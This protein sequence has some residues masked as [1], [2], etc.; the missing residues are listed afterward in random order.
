MSLARSL[1]ALLPAG[2]WFGLLTG[3]GE[4]AV[5]FARSEFAGHF[6]NVGR[7]SIWAAPLLDAIIFGVIG[8]VLVAVARRKR[9]D[10]LQVSVTVYAFLGALTLLLMYYPLHP[11]ARL[12]LAAG[13][14]VQC[15][16]SAAG[17]RTRFVTIVHATLAWPTQLWRA[18]LNLVRP[19]IVSSPG[20]ASIT[21]TRRA[22][23]IGTGATIGALAMGVHV[24]P[25]VREWSGLRQLPPPPRDA[26]NVLLV[27]L[28]TVR[29]ANLSV[30]GYHRDTTPNL[31]R[32]AAK[33]ALFRR[34][35]SHTSWT[36]PS[37][38]SLFTGRYP[39]EL[40][41]TWQTPLDAAQPTI[42][43]ILTRARYATAGFVAN[44]AY[45]S[46]RRSRPG[47]ATGAADY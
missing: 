38:G 12:A 45:C 24:P 11:W 14:G 2:L 16:R 15:G 13:I 39:H 44:T 4:S 27:V 41:G 31:A 40:S 22:F 18:I 43:E 25:R 37:H 47:F 29:A 46:E 10:L 28:D 9:L 8:A 6:N 34:A 32:L 20:A 33:G 1:A 5:R 3:F 35:Y 23:L 42:A 26:P 7:L 30:Y 36:L 19:P 21:P 17:S